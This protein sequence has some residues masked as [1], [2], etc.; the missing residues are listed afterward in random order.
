MSDKEKVTNVTENTITAPQ[1]PYNEMAFEGFLKAIGHGNIKNWSVLAEALN[2]SRTTILRWKQHPLAQ[3]AINTAV[4]EAIK[5]M[6]ESGKDDWRMHRELLK[7]FG[8]RDVTTL[9]HEAGETV[10][11]LLDKIDSGYD[12]LGRKAKKQVLANDESVQDQG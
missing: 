1:Q 3:D 8:V 5:G 10:T 11:E 2:V 7:I 9:E 4:S 6:I 12:E